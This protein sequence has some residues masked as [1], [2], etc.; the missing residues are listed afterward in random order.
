MVDLCLSLN[1]E[2]NCSD[3]EKGKSSN[4]VFAEYMNVKSWGGSNNDN[5]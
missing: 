5:R 1:I 3:I 4:K 2:F